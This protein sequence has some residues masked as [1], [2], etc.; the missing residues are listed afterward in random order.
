MRKFISIYLLRNK[1]LL[2]IRYK[3]NKKTLKA[4]IACDRLG[5]E[6]D[7]TSYLVYQSYNSYQRN[8]L[9]L[10]P[11]RR[12]MTLAPTLASLFTRFC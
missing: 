2:V 10:R 4:R 11:P 9:F 12:V 8:F 1:L 6:N 7:F 3:T 5:F